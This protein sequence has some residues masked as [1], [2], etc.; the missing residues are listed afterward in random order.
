MNLTRFTEEY[1]ARVIIYT[2]SEM[3]Y[4][5]LSKLEE[6]KSALDTCIED[7]ALL[8]LVPEINQ[9]TQKFQYIFRLTSTPT[10]FCNN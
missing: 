1:Y 2:Y 9:S 5:E 7:N 6:I 10:G 3:T 8:E 4:V